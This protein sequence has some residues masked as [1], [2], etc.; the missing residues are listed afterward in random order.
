MPNIDIIVD[1]IAKPPEDQEK[2][3]FTCP[4]G[5]YCWNIMP[6]GLK[7]A[8]A[9][10]QRE[11]TTIFH[12]MIHTIMEDYVDDILEKSRSRKDHLQ[13]LDRVFSMMEKYN[14]RLNLKKCAFGVTFEKLLRYIVS[15]KRI[16]V[17]PE[18]VKAIMEMPPL[19]NTSQ[20]RSLQG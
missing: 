17:D 16:E 9:T 3:T 8:G 12:D 11:M 18:K 13:V 4:W 15:A 19:K 5:T 7:N 20:L 1:L 2:A 6:F 10:Y 14:V